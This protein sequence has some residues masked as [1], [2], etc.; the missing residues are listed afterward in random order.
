M[1]YATLD[2]KAAVNNQVTDPGFGDGELKLE[3]DDVAYGFN[4]GL[5]LTPRDGTRFGLTYRSEVDLEFKDA[6]SL[7]NIGPN[8]QNFLDASGLTGSKVDIDM[9]IS[10][11]FV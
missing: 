9:T 8:L 2:Q 11:N 6:A 3:E 7:K 10:Y 4:L 5:M 1:L